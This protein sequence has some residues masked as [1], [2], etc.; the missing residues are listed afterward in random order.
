MRETKQN[1]WVV[2]LLAM[3]VL[4][5]GC[6]PPG[7]RAMFE[8]EALLKA[9]KHEAAVAQFE[10]AAQ[11]LPLEW[12]AWNYLG[13]ARHRAGDLEGAD[14]A[15]KEAVR[16]V[17]AR[18]FSAGHP[19]F[20]LNFNLGR[21]CLDHQQPADA[22]RHQSTFATQDQSFASCFWIAEA[23][24]VNNQPEGAAEMLRRALEKKP[25]S[26]LAWN[27]LGVMQ[28]K[29][30]NAVEAMASFETALK[31]QADFAQARRNLAITLHQHAPRDLPDRETKTLKALKEY[32]ALEPPDAAEL[33]HVADELDAALRL[34]QAP[35]TNS[36]PVTPEPPLQPL[37]QSNFIVEVPLGTNLP[38]ATIRGPGGT[39]VVQ[40]NQPVQLMPI[41]PPVIS[42]NAAVAPKPKPTPPET[43]VEVQPGVEPTPA[44]NPLPKPPGK[45]AEKPK[46]ENPD[47]PKPPPPAVKTRPVVPEVAGIARYRYTDPPR[48]RTGDREKAR[49]A[50][51]EALLQQRVNQLP[52]AEA[53]YRQVLSMDPGFQAA[54]LNLAIV[55]HGQGQLAKSMPRYETALVINPLSQKARQGFAAALNAGRY[56]IDAANEYETLLEKFPATTTA[57]LVAD[58]AAAHMELAGV[59][60]NHLKLPGR[61]KQHYRAALQLAPNHASAPAIRDWLAQNP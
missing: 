19:S 44:P 24:R 45:L 55:L 50:F 23:Y 61:A 47:Q 54:H 59:Y 25:N 15:Y 60:A 22:L 35:A 40:T 53:G 2:V 30:G 28:L 9:G 48:P 10:L 36:P 5:A 8:G 32:L 6:K 29:L 37:V 46:P 14:E 41:Q 18:Q 26:A 3:L 27:R 52:A 4:G 51:D 43:R 42:T 38:P 34:A 49:R 39:L 12:R 13:L 16:L 56:Y 33:Q 1:L 21:L 17:G 11:N 31:H 58:R 7:A 20:V 57:Q